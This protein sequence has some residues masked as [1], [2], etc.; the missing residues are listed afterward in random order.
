MAPE[1]IIDKPG[2]LAEA[3]SLRFEEEARLAIESR[4]R[5]AVALSG[6][7]VGTT[8]FPRLAKVPV[9]WSR[10][11]FFWCDE[12]ALPPSDPE[13]N[14]GLAQRLWLE[15]AGV[16]AG[17]IHRMEADAPDPERA[18]EAY[19][20]TLTQ[21]LGTPPRLDV[22]LLGVGPD[23]HICSLFPGHRLLQERERLVVFVADSPKPPPAR[24]T[25][26]LP[27]VQAAGLLVIAAFG[28][29]KAAVLREAFHDASSPLPVALAM[30]GARRV[31]VLVDPEAASRLDQGAGGFTFS[32]EAASKRL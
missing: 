22:V 31:L 16:P 7:S 11:E 13:S 3:L 6:G 24:L 28:T 15:P 10:A 23:G 4:G 12:R 5:V 2:A 9:D 19:A 8:F 30:R 21:A 18:A 17:R 20:V 1:I 25:L 14:F 29:S 32:S 27:V 26:T